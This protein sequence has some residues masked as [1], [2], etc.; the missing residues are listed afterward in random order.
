MV[1]LRGHAAG[2]NER[3]Q[4]QLAIKESALAEIL[5]GQVISDVALIGRDLFLDEGAAMGIL[6][7]ARNPTPLSRN[8]NSQRANAQVLHQQEGAA[9]QTLAIGGQDVSL[10]ST[11][12]NQLRSFYAISGKYH[13]V[14]TLRRIVQRFLE[15]AEGQRSLGKAAE[16]ADARAAMPVSR[17]DTV[18]IYLPSRFFQGLASPQYQI[19][20]RRRMRAIT[21][22]QLVQF[23]RLAAQAEGLPAASLDELVVTVLLPVGFN[24]RPDGSRVVLED[25]NLPDSLRGNR[26]TFLPVPD[27]S[28]GGVTQQESAWYQTLAAFYQSHWQQTDPLMV[29]I[30]R[31]CWNNRTANACRST[32]G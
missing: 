4:R 30:K 12:G 21:D 27:V 32:P 20:L 11:P 18:F 17:E 28:L 2:R 7:E 26:G 8:I 13:L 5:G 16:F 3:F 25:P 1:T 19:E 9:F 24:Q 10:L 22:I 23:A 6:F 29:G 31:W 14:T 15:T